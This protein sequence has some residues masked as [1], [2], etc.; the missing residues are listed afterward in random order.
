M[1][2]VSIFILCYNEETLIRDTIIHHKRLHPEAT[3]T[4][5]DNYS[6]DNSVKIAKEMGCTVIHWDR[7]NMISNDKRVEIRNEC[8][9]SITDGW[10]IVCD[11]DEWL[12]ITD[13]EFDSEEK[14][15]TT[16][17]RV[18]GYDM[19][20]ESNSES[21]DDINLQTLTIGSKYL[22]TKWL[23]FRP[24]FE[25]INF[26]NGG[27]KCSPASSEK[28]KYSKKI[29]AFKHHD[30][31]GLPFYSKKM[32]RSF[33]RTIEDR[34]AKKAGGHYSNNI[35]AIVTKFNN[36]HRTK[37]DLYFLLKKYLPNS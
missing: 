27:H 14:R 10:I 2:K 37:I 21:L 18:R 28:I 20:P 3:I 22:D 31:M 32:V 4:I 5:Y 25:E 13:E 16:L 26:G 9:K 17:L 30:L 7:G 11:M 15:G 1:T 8:W 36:R 12:C 35:N 33:E 24:V 23:A 34:K 29:Y 19:M 6:T